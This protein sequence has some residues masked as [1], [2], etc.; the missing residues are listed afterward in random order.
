MSLDPAGGNLAA[1]VLV[2]HRQ[3]AAG[4]VAQAVGEI[5]I[6]ALDQGVVAEIAVL[7]EDHFAQQVIA[8]RVGA[9]CLLDGRRAHACCP[10]ILLI[11]SFSKSSQPWAKIP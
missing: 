2:D 6:V 9:E 4:E 8:Q 11:F 10:W 7:A 1:A 3:G 5:G